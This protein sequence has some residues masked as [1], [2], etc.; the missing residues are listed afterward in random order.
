MSIDLKEFFMDLEIS[1]IFKNVP[2]LGATSILSDND[3][4]K[5][6][7]NPINRDEYI[8]IKNI[9]NYG[10]LITGDKFNIIFSMKNPKEYI[11]TNAEVDFLSL[12]KGDNIGIMPNGQGGVVRLKFKDKVP[13]ITKLLLQDNNEQFD[14]EKHSFLY[15]T[16]Q[17]VMD[18]ILEELD[19]QENPIV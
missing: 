19:K 13:E 10:D 12:R 2:Y 3:I 6:Q 16:T 11:K 15:F 18:R 8:Y 9:R 1:G 5:Y 7:L 14:K 17:E 4:L